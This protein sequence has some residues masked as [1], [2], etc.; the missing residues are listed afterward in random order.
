MYQAL[1]KVCIRRGTGSCHNR[2]RFRKAAAVINRGGFVDILWII[3]KRGHFAPKCRNCR[4]T[5]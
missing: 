2:I 5:L 1:S 4:G 3:E